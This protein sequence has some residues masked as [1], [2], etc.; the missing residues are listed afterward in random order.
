MNISAAAVPQVP[1]VV[2]ATVARPVCTAQV[3]LP[4][5]CQ[6]DVAQEAH[7]V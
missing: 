5:E 3:R 6:L 1:Q 4:T 2:R 7:T